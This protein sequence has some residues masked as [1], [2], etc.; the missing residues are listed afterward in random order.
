MTGLLVLALLIAL[1]TVVFALQ[2][3]T[4]VTVGLFAWSFEGSLALVVLVALTVGALVGILAS[5]PAV[6][7]ARRE[8]AHLRREIA[9]PKPP[10]MSPVVKDRAPAVAPTAGSTPGRPG[11][12]GRPPS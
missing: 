8:A 10:P 6:L 11:P 12:I 9:T 4:P 1:L 7:R 5:L 2:N 3:I